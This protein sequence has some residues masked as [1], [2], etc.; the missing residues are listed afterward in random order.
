MNK[1]LAPVKRDGKKLLEEFEGEGF[2]HKGVALHIRR[3]SS[4]IWLI[5]LF[6]CGFKT[7]GVG[8]TIK[9]AVEK[10][11]ANDGAIIEEWKYQIGRKRLYDLANLY[12]ESNKEQLIQK[13]YDPNSGRLVIG[14]KIKAGDLI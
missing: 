14:P 1:M 2:E 3:I 10:Y 6:N 9:E 4:T 5:S 7:R 8:R 11:D 13:T 12:F